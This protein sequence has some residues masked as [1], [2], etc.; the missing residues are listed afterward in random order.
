MRFLFVIALALAFP[1]IALAD[2]PTVKPDRAGINRLLDEF[3][4]AAV[5]QKNLARGW[6]LAAGTARTVV[7]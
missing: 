4:P 2:P 5:A 7:A 6:D 3:I 1:A